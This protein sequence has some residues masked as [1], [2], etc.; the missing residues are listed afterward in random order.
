[1]IELGTKTLLH[2]DTR[3]TFT[4]GDR[5]VAKPNSV[6]HNTSPLLSAAVVANIL[7]GYRTAE[8][9]KIELAMEFVRRRYF[10]NL[11]SRQVCIYACDNLPILQ[12]YARVHDWH[13]KVFEIT[14]QSFGP[15]DQR[16]LFRV[17]SALTDDESWEHAHSY[18]SGKVISE[19]P[20]CQEYLVVAPT[21]IGNHV[22]TLFGDTEAPQ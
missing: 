10:P 8:M 6:Y 18:W 13:A 1:M 22:A 9:R 21:L 4:T 12:F 7:S 19:S 16:Y 5:L 2:A 15:F 11:P 3:N 20:Y 17:Q 14:G